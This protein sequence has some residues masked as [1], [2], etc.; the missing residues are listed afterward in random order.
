M[1]QQ[2]P[3]HTGQPLEASPLA[4]FAQGALFPQQYRWWHGLA[5]GLAANAV[6]A[7][8][9]GRRTDQQRY[10]EGLKQAPFAPP[11]W[12]FG[13]AWTINNISVLWGN[14]RLLNLPADTPQRQPLLWLQGASWLIFSTFSYVYFNKRSPI[15]AFT[16]TG[17]MYIL[18]ICSMLL[19]S[20]IDRKIVLSL[21]TLFL[22]LSL[23]TPVAAYQMIYNE[24]P[25]LGNG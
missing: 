19:A 11:G 22:W 18:T 23:A 5:F 25:L 14:L 2:S 17:G 12:V 8:S 1:K 24:D 10:Y 6:S 21:V 16:W 4:H 20:K 7:L 13:P 9:L 15:L 3:K